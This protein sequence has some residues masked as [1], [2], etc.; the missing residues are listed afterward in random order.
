[1]TLADKGTKVTPSMARGLLR[2]YAADQPAK[3][4]APK[5]TTT[6]LRL[7]VP[8]GI[9]SVELDPGADLAQVI[10]HVLRKIQ[11]VKKTTKAAA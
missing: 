9:V 10:T 5:P 11:A 7:K 4:A 2:K 1:M 3:P 6:A 8:G